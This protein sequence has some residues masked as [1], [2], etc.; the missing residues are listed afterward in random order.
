MC[1]CRRGLCSNVI[2]L[3]FLKLMSG[4]QTYHSPCACA[5]NAKRLIP[6]RAQL[7]CE[8]AVESFPVRDPAYKLTKV[9][10]SFYTC[11][12]TS[13]SPGSNVLF[14]SPCLLSQ[15]VCAASV[16]SAV[17]ISQMAVI[18]L[19]SDCT[20][21]L[22]LVLAICLNVFP[23]I[24]SALLCHQTLLELF[25]PFVFCITGES[26][27]ANMLLLLFRVAVRR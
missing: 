22:P 14:S 24:A 11:T 7:S 21:T 2:V 3:G 13:A 17:A 8:P 26:R 4:P 23:V 9:Q 12:L 25:F 10:F 27:H 19:P 1:N 16:T 20:V 15:T 6:L 18:L 5:F